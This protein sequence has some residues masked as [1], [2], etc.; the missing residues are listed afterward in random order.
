MSDTPFS[1]FTL[2]SGGPIDRPSPPPITV[3][4]VTTYLTQDGKEFKSEQEADVHGAV[5]LKQ[6]QYMALKQEKL[7]AFQA[8]RLELYKTHGAAPQVCQCKNPPLK[9]KCIM[10]ACTCDEIGLC[11][12][13][14]SAHLP[15]N[16]KG[17][18]WCAYTDCYKNNC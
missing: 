14:T 9:N 5:L 18:Y 16:N 7:D 11:G 13:H 12:R 15:G 6:K 10:H 4:T 8:P 2:T 1:V 17:C 3:K